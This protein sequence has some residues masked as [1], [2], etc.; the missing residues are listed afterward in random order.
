MSSVS[1]PALAGFLLDQWL[2]DVLGSPPDEFEMEWVLGG[3]LLRVVGEQLSLVP[4]EAA[5]DVSVPPEVED[6]AEQRFHDRWLALSSAQREAVDAARRSA[7]HYDDTGRVALRSEGASLTIAARDLHISR[8][9][10]EATLIPA[11]VVLC[12]AD[13]T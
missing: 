3:D 5:L 10:M 7:E 2:T 13:A 12:A 9:E 11:L 6:G 1:V 8:R 4:I